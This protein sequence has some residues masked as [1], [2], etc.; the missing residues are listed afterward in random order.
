MN[1]VE[2]V[3]VMDFVFILGK[4]GFSGQRSFLIKEIQV[5]IVVRLSADR[6][7]KEIKP[8]DLKRDQP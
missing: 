7:S 2:D 1:L 4:A 8:V 3:V 5:L 6:V